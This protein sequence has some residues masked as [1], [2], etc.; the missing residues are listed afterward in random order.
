MM[1]LAD[2]NKNV[3]EDFEIDQ[4]ILFFKVGVRSQGLVSFHGS[5]YS[6]KKR[7]TPTS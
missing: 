5:N 6:I 4:Y 2:V 7:M 3:Y 1:G